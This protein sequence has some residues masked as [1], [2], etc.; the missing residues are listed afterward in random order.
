MDKELSQIKMVLCTLGHG[1]M[2]SRMDKEKK[3]IQINL[4]MKET[5]QMGPKMEKEN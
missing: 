1:K 2:I 3:F 4:F 5:I